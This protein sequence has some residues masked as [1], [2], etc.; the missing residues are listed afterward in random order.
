M[1]VAGERD[2]DGADSNDAE[3]LPPPPADAVTGDTRTIG[4]HPIECREC[5]YLPLRVYRKEARVK[6]STPTFLLLCEGCGKGIVLRVA[7]M[8]PISWSEKDG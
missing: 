8:A 1:T 2:R 4:V 7:S 6:G 3:P 5:G